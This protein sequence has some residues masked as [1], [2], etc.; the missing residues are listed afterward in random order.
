M[1]VRDCVFENKL[2]KTVEIIIRILYVNLES[3]NYIELQSILRCFTV[4]LNIIFYRNELAEYIKN[5]QN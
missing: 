2:L 1:L 4:V 3:Q 5:L